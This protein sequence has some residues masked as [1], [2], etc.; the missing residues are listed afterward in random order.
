VFPSGI[1]IG[2][3]SGVE[4]DKYGVSKIINVTPASNMNDF[5]FVSVLKRK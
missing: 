5:K 1:F 2:V 3:V 4:S